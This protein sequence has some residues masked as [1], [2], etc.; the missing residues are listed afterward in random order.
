MLHLQMEINNTLIEG[1]VDKGAFM[2][3]MSTTLVRE[4]GITHLVF[5]S[6]SY[7]NASS[8]VTQ[9]SGRISELHV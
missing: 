1:L 8:V 9:A 3:I 6:E 4:L 5:G 2:S 7:K